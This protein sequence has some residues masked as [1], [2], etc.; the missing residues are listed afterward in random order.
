MA[1]ELKKDERIPKGVRRIICDRID[2]ALQMMH[3]K[4]HSL[5]DHAVHEIRKRLKEIRGTL[6]LVR[7]QLGEKVFKRENRTFRDAGRPLS[8]L[9]DAKVMCDTL[10]QLLAHFNGRVKTD[11]AAK[12]KTA[13]SKRHTETRNKV[14]AH[15]HAISEVT[16]QIRAAKKRVEKWPLEKDGWKAIEKGIRKVYSK[17]CRAMDDVQADPDDQTLHEWRKR[18]KDLR[19]ELELLQP[20]WPEMIEPLAKQTH[21]LTDLLGDDHDLAVLK[22]IAKDEC[23]GKA[24]LDDELIFALVDE[25]RDVLQKQA[26]E[27][28]EKLY[29]ETPREFV[30]RLKGYWKSAC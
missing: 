24:S 13:L 7:D 28:G 25:R 29:Q 20:I 1:F 19:Y 3:G 14:L 5:S 27:L 9:R 18:T 12:F 16:S 11:S 2:E 8:E 30:A 22:Q 10:E 15:D 21:R 6:R 4:S 26:K 23:D 17:A